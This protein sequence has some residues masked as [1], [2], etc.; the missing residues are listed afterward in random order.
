MCR[1]TM[2]TQAEQEAIAYTLERMTD[3]YGNG[4]VAWADKQL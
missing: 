1:Y 3:L 2:L 4:D